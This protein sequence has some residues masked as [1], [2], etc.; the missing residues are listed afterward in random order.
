VS[1]FYRLRV[2]GIIVTAFHN[3]WLFDEP[4]LMFFH[5]ES[6]D[7]PLS[8]ARKVSEALEV[9][10]TSNIGSSQNMRVHENRNEEEL[11]E[12]FNRIINGMMHI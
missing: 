9:L 12:E 1:L 6:I 5:F 4:R 7:K 8:F 10:T 11:C 2:N 3:H